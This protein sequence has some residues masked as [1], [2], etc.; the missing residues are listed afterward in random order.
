MYFFTSGFKLAILF[1]EHQFGNNEC[2]SISTRKLINEAKKNNW[3]ILAFVYSNEKLSD[4]AKNIFF[5]LPHP[6]R[7]VKHISDPHKGSA[8]KKIG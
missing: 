3:N 5:E 6:G 1:I 7:T 2:C 8:A 4:W